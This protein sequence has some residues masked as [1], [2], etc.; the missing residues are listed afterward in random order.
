[1]Q[2]RCVHPVAGSNT[3]GGE[4]IKAHTVQRNGG[5]SAI[6][7]AGHVISI[8][9]AFEDLHKNAGVLIPRPVGVGSASTFTGFCNHHDTTMFRPVE[10]GAKELSAESCFLLSFRAVAYELI[11]KEAAFASL[12]LVR[13]NDRGRP[14]D[15]QIRIQEGLNVMAAGLRLGL[16]DLERWKRDYDAAYMQ[17]ESHRHKSHGVS[18]DG[19]LPVVACGAF[20]PEVD[21]DGRVLQKLGVGPA[22][23]EA[24]TFNLTVFDGRSVAVLG[25]SG[26]GDGP[27]AAFAG[28]FVDAVRASGADAVI[29]LAFEQ[30]ENTFM[31]PSWWNSLLATERTIILRHV[32]SGTP[33]GYERTGTALLGKGLAFPVNVDAVSSFING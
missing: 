17:R 9:A 3:C 10:V 25:W 8:A 18:F 21:F 24:V 29:R 26:E 5:L 20:T 28:S 16:T 11:A 30:I 23:H 7:E 12:S 33:F 15:E 22:D 31:K 1:M 27:A 32:Q 14:F 13:E 19:I 4:P 2:G 6:A